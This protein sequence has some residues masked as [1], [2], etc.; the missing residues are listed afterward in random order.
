MT[1]SERLELAMKEAG[2]TQGSLAKNVGMAQSSV[3]KLVSGGAKGSRK[4]VE[5][6]RVLGVRP[7]WLIDGTGDMRSNADEQIK[8]SISSSAPYKGLFPVEIFND[9]GATGDKLMVPSPIKSDTCRA[10]QITVNTG[11]ALVPAGTFIVVDSNESPGNEDL[12]YANVNGSN[13]VYKFIK[14]GLHGYLSVD[15]ERVP[16]LEVGNGVVISGVVVFLLRNMKN[17]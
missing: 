17:G 7:D 11:C 4:I 10:Y 15:D 16:L 3:W 9:D 13:S 14:G 8:T 12:V 2:Y 6:A 1:F 5:I